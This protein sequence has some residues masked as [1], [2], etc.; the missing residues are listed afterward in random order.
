MLD[1]DALGGTSGARGVHDTGQVVGLGRNGLSRVVGSETE[2]L[3]EAQDLQVG[4]SVGEGLNI[5]C[6]GVVLGAVD[7]DGNVL[8][9]VEW[10][11]ETG[12]Q[13]GVGEHD[14][15]LGLL[16]A[17]GETLLAE[18]VVCGHNGER[19]GESAVGRGEPLHARSSEQVQAVVGL[20]AEVGEGRADGQGHLL[21]LDE[22]LVA[23]RAELEV[24]PLLVHLLLLAVD[25]LFDLL[26]LLVHIHN[27]ARTDS[28][29]V[30]KLGSRVAQHIVQR[31]DALLGR[32]QEAILGRVVAA[33]YRFAF[34]L[35]HAGSFACVRP[36]ARCLGLGRKLLEVLTSHSGRCG[37]E[38][39]VLGALRMQVQMQ[40]Q[41]RGYHSKQKEEDK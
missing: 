20:E 28:L 23:V 5:L 4:M 7:D 12:Q 2:E 3:L 15:G 9:L 29:C 40:V 35:L 30:A 38:G 8:G 25:H 22:A 14:L 10:V 32:P 17:V 34:R 11:D 21:K 16:H 36:G 6:L 39:K 41:G 19:L 27:L 18:C 37:I 26:G 24:L 31:L 13:L 1:H 33:R